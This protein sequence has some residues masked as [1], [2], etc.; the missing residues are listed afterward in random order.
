MTRTVN[1]ENEPFIVSK[2]CIQRNHYGRRRKNNMDIWQRW[3]QT[4]IANKALVFSGAIVAL[5][6]IV[7]TGALVLQICITRENNRKA[8]EQTQQLISAADAQAKAAQSFSDSAGKINTG[9]GTAVDKLNLQA[10]KLDESVKQA[11]RLAKATEIANANVINNDR[12][13][14]GAYFTEVGFEK[15]KVPTFTMTFINTGKSPAKVTHA[16]TLSTNQNY[17]DNP[18]YFAETFLGSVTIIVPNQTSVST[19]QENPAIPITETAMEAYDSGVASYRIYANIEYTDIRTKHQYWTH[20]CWRY[21][22]DAA[23]VN[24]PFTNCREYND[25]Q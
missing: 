24:S 19:W 6:T 8:G 18:V 16:Q 23:K 9:I 22:P 21:T 5:G 11:T 17:G 7:S 1:C 12:P 3:K 14:M 20:V 2:K 25:A 13:W 10:T 15:G 4:T